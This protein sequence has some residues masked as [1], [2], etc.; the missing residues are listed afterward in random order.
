MDETT[1]SITVGS[2][3]TAG[4]SFIHADGQVVNFVTAWDGYQWAAWATAPTPATL[5]SFSASLTAEGVLVA[6]ETAQ[7]INMIGFNLLRENAEDG[8]FTQLNASLI[9]AQASGTSMGASYQ[10]LDSLAAGGSG[11][12]YLLEVVNDDG[13]VQRFSLTSCNN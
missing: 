3:V 11:C 10:F 6:W 5:V 7:E 12:D 2:A 4:G 1:L 8:S 13:S 9:P